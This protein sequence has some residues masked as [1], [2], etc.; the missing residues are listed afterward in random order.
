MSLTTHV[1]DRPG[2]AVVGVRGELDLGTADLLWD[3]L[4][5][6]IADHDGPLILDLAELSFCDSAGLAVLVRA[7][8][9]L[10]ERG[11]RLVLARPAVMV[12]RI[13]DLSGV[14]RAIASTK[15]LDEAYAMVAER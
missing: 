6:A 13:L 2:C 14:S 15:D 11:D 12:A 4:A 10:E 7:H 9:T 8:N 3:A 1:L 5:S